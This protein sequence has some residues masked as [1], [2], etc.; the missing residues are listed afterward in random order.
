MLTNCIQK[1]LC[2]ERESSTSPP[3]CHCSL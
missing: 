3:V 2:R 1:L